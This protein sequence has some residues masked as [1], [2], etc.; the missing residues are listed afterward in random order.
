MTLTRRPSAVASPPSETDKSRSVAAAASTTSPPP[1]NNNDADELL[2]T[3]STMTPAA[4][5]CNGDP[6][7]S[8]GFDMARFRN[9]LLDGF[10]VLKHGRRGS[11]HTRTVFADVELKCV[12]WQKPAKDR[13][14]K[15][16]KLEQSLLLADVLQVV[17][18][19]KT[20]VLKRSGDVAKYERYL[21]LIADDRTLDLELP[22][23][24]QCEFLRRGF[25][26]LLLHQGD[27]SG[28]L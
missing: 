3:T 19:M 2:H 28:G 4:T 7:T 5:N 23:D 21:S 15:K 22:G 18:S 8:D 1:S 13:R 24:E 16:A 12:F 14:S 6:S 10:D 11:P 9:M 27:G 26:R 17:R 25:E 20:D